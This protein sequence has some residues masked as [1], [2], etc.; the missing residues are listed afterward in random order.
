MDGTTAAAGADR[1][2]WL[3]LASV[4]GV[5]PAAA[6]RL[7][8]HFGSP[9]ALL[10]CSRGELIA[11]GMPADRARALS[12]PDW[13]AVDRACAW[14]EE[15]GEAR[16]LLTLQDVTYP[17]LLRQIA[18][19]PLLLFVRGRR[20]CL[21][22]PQLAVV[23][24]RNPSADGRGVARDFA[25]QLGHAGLTIN[26]GLAV[27][28]DAAAHEGALDAGGATIAVSGCGPDRIYPQRHADLA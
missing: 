3:A 6:Q 20:E 13:R 17:E 26:S 27:G 4:K 19:P 8:K 23:G 28:I 18:D 7:L 16:C 2:N 12:Q 5:G 24:S 1:R 14:L 11:A 22:A 25:R 9:A 21:A 15:A 10:A